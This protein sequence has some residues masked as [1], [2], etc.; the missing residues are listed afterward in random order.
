MCYTS[1]QEQMSARP[2]TNLAVGGA[3][4]IDIHCHQ[5]VRAVLGWHNGGNVNQLR[6]GEHAEC[7]HAQRTSRS[8][9]GAMRMGVHYQ[10]EQVW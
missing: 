5:I 8:H 1:A 6:T 2:C 7:A 10:E 4:R 9:V 3:L